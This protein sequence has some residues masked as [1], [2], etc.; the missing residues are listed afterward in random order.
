MDG[1][2][3]MKYFRHGILFRV[4]IFAAFAFSTP[5]LSWVTFEPYYAVSSTK[6]IKPDRKSGTETESI[7]QREEK[8][9]RAGIK[10]FRLLNLSA[11]AGQS[12]TVGTTRQQSITDDYGQIDFNSELETSVRT[13]GN[14]TKMKETQNRGKVELGI[15]PSF[16]IFI[17]K[18]KAGVSARQRIVE[19]S[20]NDTLLSRVEP[21][22][23]Y[24]PHAGAGF[25]IKFSPRMFWLA[26]Y[27][28]NFY[29]YPEL[30]PF[31]RELQ[32]SFGF[33]FGGSRR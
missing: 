33:S 3:T 10:I 32:I 25:G 24:T 12:F 20:E 29:K 2:A 17:L 13:P 15:N 1:V 22:P 21:E 6:N 19:L 7:T 31:E 26:E 27:A 28:V 30:E 9:L 11:Q 4:Y 5:A 16:S 23:T 14:E 8:G 18:A